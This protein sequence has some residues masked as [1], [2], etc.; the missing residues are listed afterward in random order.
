MKT[1]NFV[2]SGILGIALSGFVLTGCHKSAT[3]PDTDY[4]AAQDEA[5][6]SFASNDTKNVSDAAMQGTTNKYG[7]AHTI[8]SVY[9][10]NCV[11]AWD[12]TSN[13]GYITVTVNF[14]ST[15]VECKDTRWRQGEVIV[16]WKEASGRFLQAYFDSLNTITETFSGYKVGS[17][18]TP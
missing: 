16:T 4:T 14:G 12:S 11:V 7:P 2:L 1:K 15:P 9:S 17:S 13:P 10:S 5:N 8:Q 6:A 18:V 3:T